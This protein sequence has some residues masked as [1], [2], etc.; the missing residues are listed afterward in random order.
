[1]TVTAGGETD[2]ALVES[3]R[4]AAAL[5]PRRSWASPEPFVRRGET[6]DVEGENGWRV[7][8]VRYARSTM[9]TDALLTAAVGY[10]LLTGYG[11]IALVWSSVAALVMVALVSAFGGY[12]RDRLG[13][14]TEEFQTV[15]RGSLVLGAL[16]VFHEFCFHQ[17]I[18]RR[19]LFVGLPVLVVLT[20][21]HRHVRRLKLNQRRR[22]RIGLSSTLVVGPSR[23][24]AMLVKELQMNPHHGFDPVGVCLPDVEER[25]MVGGVDVLGSVADVVQI[26]VDRRIEVVV[27]ASSTLS[28]DALRRLSWALGRVKAQLVVV[29]D[30]VD[31]A[32]PRLRVR[33]ASGLSLLEVEVEA[34]ARRLVG[35]AVMDRTVGSLALLAASPAIVGFALAVK[36][37]SPG[38]AFFR[39]TRVGVDGSTFTMWK[40]R[41]M[42]VDA[43]ERRQALLASS[44]GNGTLFKMKN[45]P[46]VTP[47][48]RF[49]RRFSIDELPQL[50]NIV[51]GDMSL[52]GPRPPLEEEVETYA[53]HVGR[54][55][56]VPPGLTGLWQ[57]S[58]RS[59]LDWESAVTLDLRYVDNWSLAM[60]VA[61]LWKTARAVVRGSGAY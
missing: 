51:R 20:W 48:G 41:S 22:D 50:W 43:E 44:D 15:L 46:R 6:S 58:G 56:Q 37:T 12:R 54:R 23:R 1:M 34:P 42:Y 8:G 11:P 14:S 52:V 61:I 39:Q 13:T 9:V 7:V 29:P 28:G 2:Q 31:V 53:D 10:A 24:A 33:P 26:V 55:L 4:R 38:G 47:V 3:D 49:I 40:L 60:D 36:L 35:K 19:L 32:G 21:A 16:L 5:H 27:I 45:D 25:A 18:P 30:L 17:A 57:V 59:D